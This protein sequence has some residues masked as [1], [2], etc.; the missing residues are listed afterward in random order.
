MIDARPAQLGLPM[1]RGPER[2]P[3][4]EELARL[5]DALP[6]TLQF[7]T[8]GWAYPDWAGI[9]WSDHKSRDD[10]ERDGLIEYAAHPLLTTMYLEGGLDVQPAERDPR[11]HAS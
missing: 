3:D 4:R 10:L 2:V 6:A 7:G 8:A 5:R 1:A 9:V 11:R